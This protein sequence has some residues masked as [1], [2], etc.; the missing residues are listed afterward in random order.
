MAILECLWHLAPTASHL[1]GLQ[2][3]SF[4]TIRQGWHIIPTQRL[5][6]ALKQFSDTGK[7]SILLK[8]LQQ[9]WKTS[10][11]SIISLNFAGLITSTHTFIFP[12][13]TAIRVLPVPS[14]T[15]TGTTLHLVLWISP[16]GSLGRAEVNT[17]SSLPVPVLAAL[18]TWQLLAEVVKCHISYIQPFSRCSF[19]FVWSCHLAGFLDNFSLTILDHW[20][21]WVGFTFIYISGQR[22]LSRWTLIL[23]IWDQDLYSSNSIL[24]CV[25]SGVIKKEHLHT[26]LRIQIWDWALQKG[27]RKK[28]RRQW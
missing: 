28:G 21:G 13:L 25:F 27:R 5:S 9:I 3:V 17:T 26:N 1:L 2:Q 12:P 14:C 23:S 10:L 11:W 24:N 6:S 15:H 4:Y 8:T 19:T 20:T 7:F 22:L 18:L 16:P